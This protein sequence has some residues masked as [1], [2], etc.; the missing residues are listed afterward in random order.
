MKAGKKRSERITE[1][2]F[3][4]KAAGLARRTLLDHRIADSGRL[5]SDMK[6]P[7]F[8]NELQ[9]RGSGPS[10]VIYATD[11]VRRYLRVIA[12][13]TGGDAQAVREHITRLLGNECATRLGVNLRKLKIFDQP[14]PDGGMTVDIQLSGHDVIVIAGYLALPEN[15]NLGNLPPNPFG[16]RRIADLMDRIKRLDY[17]ERRAPEHPYTRSGGP[18]SY[19][20]RDSANEYVTIAL[21]E[22]SRVMPSNEAREAA[23]KAMRLEDY[24]EIYMPGRGGHDGWQV[25]EA[26]EADPATGHPAL[27]ARR[28]PAYKT[29]PV[30][31]GG[32]TRYRY[33]VHKSDSIASVLANLY[34][35]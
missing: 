30:A 7:L 15:L 4:E 29:I 12:Q 9:S 34:E 32:P 31:S 33:K 26:S 8:L 19:Q 13:R 14:A 3:R 22:I 16:S 5:V 21:N 27:P 6:H 18:T 10:G 25:I 28:V 2:S 20:L 24:I 17:A 35:G 23:L 11:V 1:E